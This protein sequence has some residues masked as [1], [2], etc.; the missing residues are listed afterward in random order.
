MLILFNYQTL[1]DLIPSCFFTQSKTHSVFQ[2]AFIA[3]TKLSNLIMVLI[4]FFTT[5]SFIYLSS[6]SHFSHYKYLTTV[7]TVEA[8]LTVITFYLFYS[9]S[10]F[11]LLQLVAAYFMVYFNE[12]NQ[13][14]TKVKAAN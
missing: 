3:S 14:A 4:I 6:L 2:T 1:T 13:R 11:I 8:A 5:C 12:T 10:V 9:L 7:F